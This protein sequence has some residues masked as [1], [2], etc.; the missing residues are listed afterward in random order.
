MGATGCH[1]AKFEIYLSSTMND[2]TPVE[3][4][5]I[6]RSK[7]K[8]AKSFGVCTHLYHRSEGV[9]RMGGVTFRDEAELQQKA[10]LIISRQVAVL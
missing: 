7:E 8:L 4:A 3:G 2:G 1:N 9:W 5:K 6:Q 10:V